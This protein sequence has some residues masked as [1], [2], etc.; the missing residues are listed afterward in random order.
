MGLRN[1]GNERINRF[2]EQ[3]IRKTASSR[4]LRGATVQHA[5]EDVENRATVQK[6]SIRQFVTPGIRDRDK[7]FLAPIVAC[8]L[9]WI[10]NVLIVCSSLILVVR[11]IKDFGPSNKT[12]ITGVLILLGGS[13]CLLVNRLLYE[14]TIAIFEGI[15]H[16][17]QIRDELKAA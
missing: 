14:F 1:N 2:P 5:K 13:L 17:R 7:K 9:Y 10:F 12:I 15:K 3:Q 11:S 8:I 6:S 4:T 16:L